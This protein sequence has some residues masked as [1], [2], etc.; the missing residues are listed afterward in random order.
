MSLEPNGVVE[1]PVKPA[2]MLFQ[3]ATSAAPKPPR[4]R[5]E[6]PAR[7]GRVRERRDEDRV[8]QASQDRVGCPQS[9]LAHPF[10]APAIRPLVMRRWTMRKKISTGIVNRVEEAMIDPQST[11]PRP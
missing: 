3:S 6:Y 7:R 5:V 9:V 1:L 10:T 11:V 8:G 4:V 2:P